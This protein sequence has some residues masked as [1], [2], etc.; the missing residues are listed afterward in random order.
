MEQS[1]R[2]FLKKAAVGSAGVFMLNQVGFD[3]TLLA[4]EEDLSVLSNWIRHRGKKNAL[5]NHYY[6]IAASLLSERKE[7]VSQLS[8]KDQWESRQKSMRGKII[9]SIGGEFP[10]KTPLNAET[11]DYVNKDNYTIEKVVFESLL[12][13]HVTGCLFIPSN[14]ET[15][16]PA[17]IYCS[18][19]THEAFRAQAYQ[20]EILNLVKKGFVVFAIDPIGQG[21]RLHYYNPDLGRSMVG[22]ATKEHSYPGAQCFLTGTSIARYFIWDGIRAVDYL[23]SREE[24]DPDRL[25][26]TGRSGGGTQSAYIGALDD[27]ILA[28]APECYITSFKRLIQSI[29]PQDAEQNFYHGIKH[30]IDHAD[31]LEQRVPKPT[32]MV[33]TTRDFFSIQGA[34][35]TARE[36]E[37]VYEIFGEPGNFSMIE[38]NAPHASTEKNRQRKYAF[39]QQHFNVPGNSADEPVEYLTPE[40]LTVT[41]TGQVL[42]S[43]KGRSTFQINKEK[44]EKHI[45]A[46]KDRRKSGADT[47]KSILPTI[48]KLSGFMSPQTK[49]DPVC[50]GRYVREDYTIEKYFVNGTGRYKIP[51]LLFR[52]QNATGKLPVV[53]YLHPGGKAAEASPGGEI[54]SIVKKGYAVLAP[55][56]VGVGEL[57]PAGFNG[58]AYQFELGRGAYNIWFFGI[59]VGKSM[60]GTQAANI[61]R[62][63]HVLKNRNDIATEQIYSLARGGL[64]STLLHAAAFGQSISKVALINP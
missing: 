26:I 10:A 39:F 3:H 35:E 37:E 29:G 20:H 19:H 22:G 16:K 48:K 17:I 49:H 13:Y 28:S 27:R 50:T 43:R 14:A 47:V 63:I 33:T 15:K 64:C 5:Y 58:D 9:Q 60:V 36:V 46:L 40:E 62:L 23:L 1:R 7:T 56:L 38:D 34:R 57:G 55:D 25:G 41:E 6:S 61:M 54:E 59:L 31:L 24:V 44:A 32:L 42:T 30:Q 2:D 45:T 51:Y 18:G 21:E 8:T 4:Q 11:T 12:E 53:L 52:P